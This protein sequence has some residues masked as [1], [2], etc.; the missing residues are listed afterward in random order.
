MI[1]NMRNVNFWLKFSVICLLALLS[2]S[3]LALA[4]E[5]DIY[6]EDNNHYQARFITLNCRNDSGTVI[7]NANTITSNEHNFHQAG[8]ED[9]FMVELV[10]G[11]SYHFDIK[12][13]DDPASS[14]FK[15]VVE[16]YRPDAI[17]SVSL[18]AM[19]SDRYK[20][21]KS[22]PKSDYYYV[23][24]KN[25]DADKF[26]GGMKYSFTL[27]EDS[28][29]S[30]QGLFYGFVY[31]ADTKVRIPNATISI[32]S[33]HAG[34]SWNGT[35]SDVKYSGQSHSGFVGFYMSPT[36]LGSNFT[37]TV[38]AGV[39][40]DSYTR[41]ET[42]D[43]FNFIKWLDIYLSHK[44]TDTVSIKTIS[45]NGLTYICPIRLPIPFRLRKF[46][47]M[48]ITMAE[49]TGSVL[50]NVWNVRRFPAIAKIVQETAMTKIHQFILM[51]FVATE[52]MTTVTGV[53]MKQ[54]VFKKVVLL[55]LLLLL[56]PQRFLKQQR[57][58]HL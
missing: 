34:Q 27:T 3:S 40:Y 46:P 32:V 36:L 11:K 18:D 10:S 43:V 57:L 13:E 38:D 42:I 12:A 17:T 14:D 55:L 54:L 58:Q 1:A 52:K 9:W 56:R 30:S 7:Y 8:D 48:R 41:T 44:A 45:L 4:I 49:A 25:L 51:K 28:G 15:P 39:K 16:L 29:Q 31:D 37:I 53:L 22:I 50:M 33:D 20:T 47:K 19:G 5:P 21:T 35:I 24:V 6:E 26:G 23:R 2:L